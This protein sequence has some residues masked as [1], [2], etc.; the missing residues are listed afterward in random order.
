M[1]DL[2]IVR[3]P[4]APSTFGVYSNG[5]PALTS[6][7]VT[8]TNGRQSLVELVPKT[9]RTHQLRVHMQYIGTPIAGDRVYGSAKSAPRLC[10]HAHELEITIPQ[11][12]RKVFTASVPTLF[13]ELIDA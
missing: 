6:Y 11:A 8:A 5:K 10:L 12:E 3:N 1:I 9:G 2:P 4:S 7:T 13:K